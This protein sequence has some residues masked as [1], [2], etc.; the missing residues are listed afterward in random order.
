MGMFWV[1]VRLW[2]GLGGSQYYHPSFARMGHPAIPVC[3]MASADE[4]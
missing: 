4:R 1:G 2:G 3:A